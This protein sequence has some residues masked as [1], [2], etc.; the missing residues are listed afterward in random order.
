MIVRYPRISHAN[1]WDLLL[2]FHTQVKPSMY[3]TGTALNYREQI[4]IA[5]WLHKVGILPILPLSHPNMV[6]RSP[7]GGG[8]YSKTLPIR[9]CAAQRGRDLEAPDLERGIKNCGSR[10]YLLLKIVAD[11]VEA[12]IWCISRTNKEIPFKKNRA[13]SITNFLERSIKIGP[14]LERSINFRGI[15]F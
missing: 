10:L 15:F 8:G 6:V 12:F 11:Y 4:T 13:M 7:G 14:F 2:S 1:T 5:W 3:S 9:V